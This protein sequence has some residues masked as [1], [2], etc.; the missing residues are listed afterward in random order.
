MHT[1]TEVRRTAIG[2]LSPGSNIE[3]GPVVVRTSYIGLRSLLHISVSQHSI[4]LPCACGMRFPLHCRKTTLI[5][6]PQKG[7]TLGG[8][9]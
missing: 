2:R 9:S 4:V 5:S 8:Y 3:G 1:V 6:F 7:C